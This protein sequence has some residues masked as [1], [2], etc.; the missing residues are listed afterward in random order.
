MGQFGALIASHSGMCFVA[1]THTSIVVIFPP[2]FVVVVAAAIVGAVVFTSSIIIAA[3][4]VVIVIVSICIG[5]TAIG[6]GC[7]MI[8]QAASNQ[9]TSQWIWLVVLFLHLGSLVLEP[10]LDLILVQT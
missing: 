1:K 8:V 7:T 5:L 4:I 6:C 10:D 3:I 9:Q 2:S